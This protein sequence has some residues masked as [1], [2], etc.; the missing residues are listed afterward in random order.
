M[1]LEEYG[2]I[3]PAILSLLTGIQ[4]PCIMTAL[5]NNKGHLKNAL[6]ELF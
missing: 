5:E 2:S 1:A 4:G 3:K 6:K